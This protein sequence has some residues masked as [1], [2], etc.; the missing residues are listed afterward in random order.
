MR[1]LPEQFRK[2]GLDYRLVVRNDKVALY[3]LTWEGECCGWE[4]ARIFTQAERILNGRTLQAS[5]VLPSNEK[6]GTEGILTKSQAFHSA[7]RK[8]AEEYF[9]TLSD[10]LKNPNGVDTYEK[11]GTISS[12]RYQSATSHPNPQSQ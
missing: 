3:E 5:E 12:E 10:R 9:T 11:L 4:V 6:F 7:N 2:N 8:K 1:Q